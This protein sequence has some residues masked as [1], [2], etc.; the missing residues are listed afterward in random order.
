[1]TLL[2]AHIH[3][4]AAQVLLTNHADQILR[5]E[6]AM[7]ERKRPDVARVLRQSAEQIALAAEGWQDY[8][9]S[10]RGTAEVP[11]TGALEESSVGGS[12]VG[13]RQVADMLSLSSRQVG[14]LIK[15]GSLVGRK[16][17]G[18]WLVHR[19]SVIAYLNFFNLPEDE[20]A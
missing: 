6:A 1:V 16:T 12:W 9:T 4:A 18:R 10:A 19:P 20:I 2:G 15:D 7:V 5:N 8:V 14:N 13:T 3:P 11:Q 17:A